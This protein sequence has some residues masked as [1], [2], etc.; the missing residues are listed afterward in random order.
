MASN[1]YGD[2]VK[3]VADVKRE[4]VALD[5]D[6]HSDLE[7]LLLEDGS[8]QEDLWGYNIYP[9]LDGEDFIE[10]DSLINIRPRQNNFSRDVEDV[11]I[12]KSIIAI[13]NKYIQR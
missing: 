9:E 2:M 8:N 6:L 3:A 10:F 13:T 4:L 11:Q 5:S 1:R 12:Q 7:T